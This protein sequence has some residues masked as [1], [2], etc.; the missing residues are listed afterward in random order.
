MIST[1]SRLAIMLI[2]IFNPSFS[3]AC[4]FRK[5][6]PLGIFLMLFIIFNGAILKA[7]TFSNR[8]ALLEISSCLKILSFFAITTSFAISI[9]ASS[10]RDPQPLVLLA[11]AGLS[12]AAEPFA[13]RTQ[14]EDLPEVLFVLFEKANL[15]VLLSFFFPEQPTVYSANHRDGQRFF[16]QF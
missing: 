7:L 5:A 12:E 1:I 13:L 8:D 15:S 9:A 2:A 16:P 4:F 11:L 6:T 14:A 3:F 10:A